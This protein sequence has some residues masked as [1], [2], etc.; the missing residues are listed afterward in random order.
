M[1]S[2]RART[3]SDLRRACLGHAAG[4]HAAHH[5]KRNGERESGA[6]QRSGGVRVKKTRGGAGVSVLASG[7]G[8]TGSQQAVRVEFVWA[9]CAGLATG[10]LGLGSHLLP[11]PG[12]STPPVHGGAHSK[13]AAASQTLRL[14]SGRWDR[15]SSSP[16]LHALRAPAASHLLHATL[17]FILPQAPA[18]SSARLSHPL[19]TPLNPLPLTDEWI[20]LVSPFFF[21][22]CSSPSPASPPPPSP[23]LPCSFPSSSSSSSSS[24]YYYYYYYYL[25]SPPLARREGGALPPLVGRGREEAANRWE[26]LALAMEARRGRRR[27]GRPGGEG[28]PE[29]QGGVAGQAG[30]GCRGA[31]GTEKGRRWRGAPGAGNGAMEVQPARRGG[32]AGAARGGGRPAGGPAGEPRG[33]AARELPGTLAPSSLF[34]RLGVGG[35]RGLERREKRSEPVQHNQWQVGKFRELTNPQPATA[36][37]SLL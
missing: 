36:P 25:R 15:G 32:A 6:A 30:R 19:S 13:A 26:L 18:S 24:S 16:L 8:Q 37:C 4:I 34:H 1:A 2:S 20:P 27:G 33:R 10:I 9:G 17:T 11:P 28:P 14:R 23:L 22:R 29:S 12:F 7:A 35:C 31:A 3:A 5:G 21:L